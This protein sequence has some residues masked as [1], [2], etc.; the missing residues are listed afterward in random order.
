MVACR[1]WRRVAR[2]VG[3]LRWRWPADVFGGRLSA[4][5]DGAGRFAEASLS[6]AVAAS[7]R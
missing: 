1:V 7:P 5:R 4:R 6:A 3:A 2:F